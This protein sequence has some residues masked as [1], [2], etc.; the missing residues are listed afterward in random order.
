VASV[1]EALERAIDLFD[2]QR[3]FEAHEFF[4]FIWKSGDVEPADRDFW[5]GTTQV[6]VGCCHVQRGNLRGALVLLDRAAGYLAPYPSPYHGIDTDAL[7]SLALGVAARVRERGAS[8]DVPFPAFP[9]AG[10]RQTPG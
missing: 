6:A 7:R 2:Q 10:G 9:V 5:K 1:D 3:F 4:E 8:T